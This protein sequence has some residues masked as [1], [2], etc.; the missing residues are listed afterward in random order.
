MSF[1]VGKDGD[2]SLF[3]VGALI[4]VVGIL[5]IGGG[6][7]AFFLDQNT[8]KAPLEVEPFPQATPWGKVNETAST[9]RSVYLVDGASPEDVEAYYQ[10]K[11]QGLEGQDSTCTRLPAVGVLEASKT[12]P[13]V[14][15]YTITCLFQRSGLQASQVTTVKIQPGVFNSDPTLNTQGKTVIEHSERWQP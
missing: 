2:I 12:D 11:L 8:Y 4:A 10:Q 13:S 15:P 3:R 14:V 6:I 1:I 7:A 9:R 5:L